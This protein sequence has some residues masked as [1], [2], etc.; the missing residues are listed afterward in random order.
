MDALEHLEFSGTK[1][2]MREPIVRQLCE[3][4]TEKKGR[5][6]IMFFHTLIF[7]GTAGLLP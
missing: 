2:I 1:I 7:F 3:G 4:R 5:K 6:K